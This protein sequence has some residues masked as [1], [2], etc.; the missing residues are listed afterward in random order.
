MGRA[1]RK[2]ARE[3]AET[4]LLTYN[5]A[6]MDLEM[7]ALRDGTDSDTYAAAHDRFVHAEQAV[8]TCNRRLTMP[9]PE[10]A[11]VIRGV[12]AFLA[13][14]RAGYDVAWEIV[15]GQAD[16]VES[17]AGWAAYPYKGYRRE[18]IDRQDAARVA[19]H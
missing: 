5:E 18:S 17:P 10:P 12:E 13:D 14:L 11:Q 6:R 15:A 3:A 7:T 16:P 4:V 8:P 19:E 2:A 9:L 1:E